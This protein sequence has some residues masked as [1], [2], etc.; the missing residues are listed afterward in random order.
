MNYAEIMSTMVT[1]NT[2][3]RQTTH[4]CNKETEKVSNTNS[5]YF[6]TVLHISIDCVL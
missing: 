2:G 5:F 4:E 1:Y 3:R 6:I